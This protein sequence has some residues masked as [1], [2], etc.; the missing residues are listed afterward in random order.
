MA[1][2]KGDT[3]YCGD[4]QTTLISAS[5][6]WLTVYSTAN[7]FRVEST[8]ISDVGAVVQYKV[9]LVRYPTICTA[10]KSFT[11]T[12]NPCEVTSITATNAASYTGQTLTL[13]I[14]GSSYTESFPTYTQSPACGYAIE[15][16]F[17]LESS[18][19]APFP[20]FSHSSSTASTFTVQKTVRT[21]STHLITFKIELD[22]A[23]C[24]GVCEQSSI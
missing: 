3:G 2:T 5:K 6:T 8:S 14:G 23:S 13:Q 9:C 11:V 19:S 4:H 7:S 17:I 12:I 15:N 21:E 18:A 10:T 24:V 1:N 16:Y 20:P 22:T